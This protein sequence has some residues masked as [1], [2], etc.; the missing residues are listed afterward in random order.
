MTIKIPVLSE[1]TAANSILAKGL[2]ARFSEQELLVLNLMASPGAGKTTLL[3]RSIAE[4]NGALKMAVIEGDPYTSIDAERIHAAGVAAVEINTGGGCHLEARMI[5]AALDQMEI[6]DL[7]LIVIENVGNLICPTG[8]D[9]GEDVK[10]ILV[11]LT[12]GDDKPLKYPMGFRT[13]DAAVISKIDLEPYLSA[14]T[15][16]MRENALTVNPDLE[17]FALSSVTGEG[18]DR[19]LE[20]IKAQVAKKQSEAR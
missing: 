2:R 19:F 9:L 4:L 3:E 17:I 11:S 5:Q 1:V 14:K 18:V 7:D 6:D 13:A 8:W 12:E 16:A 20:W 15:S 10:V